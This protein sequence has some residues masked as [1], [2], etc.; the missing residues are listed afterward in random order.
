[1]LMEKICEFYSETLQDCY[2]V[3]GKIDSYKNSDLTQGLERRKSSGK[4][5][6]IE[7][8]ASQETFD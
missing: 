2:S 5:T 6:F 4:H 7:S 1:M 3:I 8:F